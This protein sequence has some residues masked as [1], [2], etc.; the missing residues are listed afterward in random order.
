MSDLDG[1]VSVTEPIDWWNAGNTDYKKIDQWVKASGLSAI[2][3]ITD[4]GGTCPNPLLWSTSDPLAATC[5][6]KYGVLL[7]SSPGSPA[8]RVLLRSAKGACR[9]LTKHTSAPSSAV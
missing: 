6:L 9:T 1:I 3:N 2:T 5:K 8:R 7:R 4:L